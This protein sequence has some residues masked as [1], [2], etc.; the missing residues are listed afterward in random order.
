MRIKKR[1]FEWKTA[2]LYYLYRVK[3][4][5][6]HKVV[7]C[8]YNGKGYGCNPKYIA[9]ALIRRHPDWDYVW[10]VEND[11]MNFPKEIRTVKYN[12]N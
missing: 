10:L 6:M 12:S 4:I 5:D 7:F 2:L 1:I 8:N 11:N 3:P 9:E